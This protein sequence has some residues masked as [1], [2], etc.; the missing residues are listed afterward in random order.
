MTHTCCPPCRLRFEGAAAAH[1]VTCPHCGGLP[2]RL[3]DARGVLGF[4][5]SRVDVLSAPPMASAAALTRPLVPD[6]H[7]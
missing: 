2:T 7:A 1:L 3:P 6:P 4:R 5:L